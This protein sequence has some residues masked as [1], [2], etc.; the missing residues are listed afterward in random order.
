MLNRHRGVGS[1]VYPI[2]SE[3]WL[4]FTMTKGEIMA[5]RQRVLTGQLGSGQNTA[6]IKLPQPRVL[7]LARILLIASP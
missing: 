7:T 3:F 4:A 6:R 1:A 5:L 2:C